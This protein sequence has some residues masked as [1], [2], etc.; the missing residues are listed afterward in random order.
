MLYSGIGRDI[1]AAGA[2]QDTDKADATAMRAFARDLRDTHTSQGVGDLLRA[3]GPQMSGYMPAVPPTAVQAPSIPGFD[4]SAP[5]SVLSTPGRPEV[6]PLSPLAGAR[7]NRGT[8]SA[9]HEERRLPV[10]KPSGTAYLDAWDTAR[11]FS[12]AYETTSLEE[13]GWLAV[14]LYVESLPADR[15]QGLAEVFAHPTAGAFGARLLD[16]VETER[17]LR[18]AAALDA[19]RAAL[20]DLPRPEE[21]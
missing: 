14:R 10:D 16:V 9:A 6:N 21:P 17:L 3:H 4:T 8:G 18:R 5:A 19:F 15:I 2:G 13:D 12:M 11:W 7:H 20:R 1:A